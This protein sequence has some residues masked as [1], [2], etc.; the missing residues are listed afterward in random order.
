MVKRILVATDASEYSRHALIIAVEY[1]KQFQAEIELLHVVHQPPLVYPELGGYF[2]SYSDEQIKEIGKHVLEE[3]LKGIDTGQVK[4]NRKIVPG[5]PQ[6]AILDEI[7][8]DIDLVI[9]GT[10]GH[11][12]IAGA[13]IGSVTQRVLADAPCPVLVVK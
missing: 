4:I 12:P 2:F 1:A 5:Y 6:T 10:R 7:K 9:L 11:S 8:R 13:L 3:T